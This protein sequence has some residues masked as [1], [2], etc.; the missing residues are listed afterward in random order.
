MLLTT[1]HGTATRIAARQRVNRGH[2]SGR[3]TLLGGPAGR[4]PIPRPARL[5]PTCPTRSPSHLGPQT[6]GALL[7]AA[8]VQPAGV[9]KAVAVAVGIRKHCRVVRGAAGARR[10]AQSQPARCSGAQSAAGEPQQAACTRRQLS[11]RCCRIPRSA[12]R[13]RGAQPGRR[14]HNKRGKGRWVTLPPLSPLPCRRVPPTPTSTAQRLLLLLGKGAALHVLPL[15]AVPPARRLRVIQQA[16]RLVPAR[17]C[18]A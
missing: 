3:A 13:K 17:A 15:V 14:D 18:T 2:S 5:P 9:L 8:A 11:R 7:L 16:S 10:H 6:L 4:R 1:C 12:G